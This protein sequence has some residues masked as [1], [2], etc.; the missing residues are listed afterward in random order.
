LIIVPSSLV[1]S[2]TGLPNR[3][4]SHTMTDNWVASGKPMRPVRGSKERMASRSKQI[5]S[6]LTPVD[7]SRG[8]VVETGRRIAADVAAGRLLPG[9]RLPTEQELMRA[10]GVSRTVIREAVATLRA[11]GLIAT[12]H[13]IG[14][15]V[16]DPPPQALFR[17]EPGQTE[18]LSDA[19]HIMELRTAV[20]TEAAGLA[21]ERATAA[22]RRAIR[23]TLAA[24][25]QAIERGEAAVGEDFAFHAA[26]TDATGNPQFRRFL[27]FLGRFI[28]PR[29]SVRIRALNLRAYLMT[30]QQ[31]HRA[32]VA[33]IDARS[34]EQA[35]AAMRTHLLMS[36]ERYR[37]L[38]PDAAVS[39]RSRSSEAAAQP[40][41]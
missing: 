37:A 31:E 29:A 19:L 26:I 32:I 15:F 41:T 13:G 17:I 28:I 12:R 5:L 7:R 22:Q 38:A 34:V 33:A 4:A 25:D 36:R 40:R 24:I 10:M 27:D 18:T 16:A 30:F 21:A 11:E 6:S 2:G 14:S 8:L 23:Q 39:R 1:R 35:R 9:T 3:P 20:E